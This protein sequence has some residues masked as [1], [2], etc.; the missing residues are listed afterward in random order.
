MVVFIE[1]PPVTSLNC[2]ETIKNASI[3]IKLVKSVAWTIALVIAYSFVNS[4]YPGNEGTH[5]NWKKKLFCV[6]IS[7][8]NWFQGAATSECI[9]IEKRK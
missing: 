4:C 7:H 5:E 2:Y 3:L 6:D 9:K 8:E 1:K